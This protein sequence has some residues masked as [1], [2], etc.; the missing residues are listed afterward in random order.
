MKTNKFFLPFAAL[1][2]AGLSSCS[3]EDMQVT[4]TGEEVNI[5]FTAAMTSNPQS[6]TLV[7]DGLTATNLSYV[8]FEKS[9][10]EYTPLLVKEDAATFNS[11]VATVSIALVKGKTYTIGFWADAADAPY[12]LNEDGTITV[13]YDNLTAND[14][15]RDAFFKAVEIKVENQMEE[16]VTLQ[17]PLAQLNFATTDYY[18][19]R[20]LGADVRATGITIKA[21]VPN[22][23]SLATGYT[24]GD[25]ERNLTFAQAAMPNFGLDKEGNAVDGE[26]GTITISKTDYQYLAM[27][28][29]LPPV[30][31]TTANTNLDNVSLTTDKVAS[32]A[33]VPYPSVPVRSNYRT[34]I[35][36]SLL[37]TTTNF[38]I[39]IDPM[40]DGN[41]N[42]PP[43]AWDGTR[44]KPMVNEA[45]KTVAI[46]SPEEL[47]GLA[48]LVNEGNDFEGYTI[49]LSTPLDLNGQPWTTIGSGERSKVSG[50]G[51]TMSDDSKVF[52]GTFDGN[53]FAITGLKLEG[54]TGDQAAG[55]FGVTSGA[56]IKNLTFSN[57][58]INLP[59]C[60]NLGCAAGL[61]LDGTT[62]SGVQ[63]KE[64]DIT[65]KK[66]VGAIVGRMT[67]TGTIEDCSSN[68]NITSTGGNTGGIVGAAYYSTAEGKMTIT[69]CHNTGTITCAAGYTGGIAGLSAA[70]V[71]G[72]TNTGTVTGKNTSVGGIVGEQVNCGSVKNCTNNADVTVTSASYG[73]GGIIGWIRYNGNLTDY[74][75]KEVIEVSGNENSGTI[76]SAGSAGGIAGHIYH[77][78]KVENNVNKAASITGPQFA[79][80]IVGTAQF[81]EARPAGMD[82]PYMVTLTDNVTYTS[83]G[84]ITSN[85]PDLFVY[86][87]SQG[88]YV[89]L[90]GNQYMWDGETASEPK[91]LDANT[92]SVSYPDQFLGMLKKLADNDDAYS[93]KTVRLDADVDLNGLQIPSVEASRLTID[94]QGHTLSN[95]KVENA[96]DAGL[97]SVAVTVT[98]KDLTISGADVTATVLNDNGYAGA[99]IG[100]TF[101]TITL[102]NVHVENST[103]N[104]INKVGGMIGFCAENTVNATGCSV[105]GS[106]VSVEYIEGESGQMGGF[107]GYITQTGSV[108]TD[109]SVK[110]TVINANIGR[111]D[112]KY[113]EFAGV[114][115]G[116]G[117][118]VTFN[119][120]TCESNTINANDL[121]AANQPTYGKILG[122]VRN[123]PA[124]VIIDGNTR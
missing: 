51:Y 101:G 73:T 20:A 89:T 21:T 90:S 15:S 88:A 28:Y 76:T 37:T 52:K 80:G 47:A 17:R 34:N 45:A 92:Y 14:E 93:N 27:A 62:V 12:T 6:R 18:E 5:A 36:G 72:C 121:A 119:N 58:D 70:D 77:F 48:D 9:G 97:I 71:E 56:T 31:G 2:I 114:F 41:I 103:I 124:T 13:S 68:A 53:G 42:L 50:M 40:P 30:T 61:A 86:D 78:A 66:G 74:A 79:A 57:Y 81:G 91:Q 16:R 107:I 8:V 83:I 98:V 94:G 99:L 4:T 109:C 104:G 35:I 10:D 122:G 33:D 115:H 110:N 49:T 87:N 46:T 69:N 102:N 116:S 22:T 123:D 108:F 100:H 63:V 39:V 67:K 1:A 120:I 64:G 11:K 105:Q 32:T 23:I 43:T 19:A 7:S 75:L 106:E 44:T 3:Q 38:E 85:F 65:A 26:C 54:Y 82:D 117:A 111:A 29:V 24:S 113:A 118:T 112:R 96:G 25:A 55:L 95:Y 59:D 60:E 84:K